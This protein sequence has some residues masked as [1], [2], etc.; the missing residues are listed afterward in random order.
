MHQVTAQG[1]DCND[2]EDN[3]P[4]D[5]LT[6]LQQYWGD[7][8]EFNFTTGGAGGVPITGVA[9]TSC[10]WAAAA[11]I[12]SG[13]KTI[14]AR[15]PSVSGD[16]RFVTFTTNWDAATALGAHEDPQSPATTI[17]LFDSLLGVTTRV[18]TPARSTSAGSTRVARPRRLRRASP[19]ATS[20]IG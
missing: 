10:N 19:C 7:A 15:T 1:R 13:V 2:D 17:A 4:N 20:T 12:Q 11:G 14:G 8:A 16:G 18:G 6:A 5:L 3:A 9:S